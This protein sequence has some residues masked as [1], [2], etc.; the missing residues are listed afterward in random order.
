MVLASSD[1][2]NDLAAGDTGKER[3]CQNDNRFFRAS[4]PPFFSS[5]YAAASLVPYSLHEGN[6]VKVVGLSYG[7]S[8]EFIAQR[9]ADV[10]EAFCLSP[11]RYHNFQ[12][13]SHI[14]LSGK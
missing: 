7:S 10:C 4:Q 8:S 3:N 5:G 9:L 12:N 1:V 6:L 11:L 2:T 14:L 13:N